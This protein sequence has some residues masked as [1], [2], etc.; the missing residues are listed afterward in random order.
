MRW[1]GEG[2]A[3]ADR[4]IGPGVGRGATVERA[5]GSCRP[6]CARW[7][8]QGHARLEPARQAILLHPTS[9]VRQDEGTGQKK[10]ERV[11]PGPSPAPLRPWRTAFRGARMGARQQGG[12]IAQ[13]KGRPPWPRRPAK[14]TLLRG[15]NC[16]CSG[17]STDVPRR[18]TGT[19]PCVQRSG[20][21]RRRRARPVPVRAAAAFGTCS[22]S[23]KN[24]LEHGRT[25]LNTGVGRCSWQL[26]RPRRRLTRRRRQH[27]IG[28]ASGPTRAP[29]L[30]SVLPE[31]AGTHSQPRP[32]AHSAQPPQILH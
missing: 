7:R 15:D 24:G 14:E 6:P 29:A 26:T 13:R 23:S 8:R 31:R 2:A 32:L 20:A 19:G 11:M 4:T 10:D 18:R 27:A 5:P 9:R 30:Q 16:S 28:R 17:G 1:T 22:A 21:L 12:A 25:N 3:A